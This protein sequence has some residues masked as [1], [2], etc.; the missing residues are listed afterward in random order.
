MTS[1]RPW[2]GMGAIRAVSWTEN[3]AMDCGKL[4]YVAALPHG[5]DLL[6]AALAGDD[7]V[8]IPELARRFGVAEG[9]AATKDAPFM[10]SLL[11]CPGRR[12]PD[13]AT[14]PGACWL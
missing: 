12:H 3:L 8:V 5:E 2:R 14:A 11:R 1:S 7:R 4:T 13:L 9:L 10:A 6:V